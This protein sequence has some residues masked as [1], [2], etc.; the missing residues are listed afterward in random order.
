MNQ[1]LLIE[2]REKRNSFLLKF[3]YMYQK[4]SRAALVQ[5]PQKPTMSGLGT[6]KQNPKFQ[7]P[8]H[9]SGKLGFLG[10]QI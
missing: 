6:Q 5:R 1:K 4:N 3:N 2:S 8:S 10:G 9:L 7:I